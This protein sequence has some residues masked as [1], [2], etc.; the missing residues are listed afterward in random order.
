MAAARAVLSVLWLLVCGMY[1]DESPDC[2]YSYRGRF[3]LF[4][5]WGASQDDQFIHALE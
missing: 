5:H 2:N 4:L 1:A 3:D